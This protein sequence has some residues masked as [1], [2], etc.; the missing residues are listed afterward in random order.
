M[1]REILE[2][3]EVNE[4]LD[5]GLVKILSDWEKARKALDRMEGKYYYIVEGDKQNEKISMDVV[6]IKEITPNAYAQSAEI[7][8]VDIT[9]IGDEF[10]ETETRVFKGEMLEAEYHNSMYSTFTE[11]L[12]VFGKLMK[13]YED[14]VIMKATANLGVNY[15]KAKK[16]LA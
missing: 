16:R 3:E 8:L 2:S 12:K 13:D 4:K 9:N 14:D 15:P 5:K 11:A 1:I 6:I 10:G 7:F